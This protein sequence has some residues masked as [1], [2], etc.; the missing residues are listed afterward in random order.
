M[1]ALRSKRQDR[2]LLIVLWS[3]TVIVLVL[4]GFAVSPIL[5]VWG[6]VGLLAAIY[7]TRIHVRDTR[8]PGLGA[9]EDEAT[10]G[11][12]PA[13]AAPG[14]RPFRP[15]DQ[16]AHRPGLHAGPAP[17]GTTSRGGAGQ[18]DARPGPSNAMKEPS[19]VEESR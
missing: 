13:A 6:T 2:T 12:S 14:G 1:V 16:P 11:E 4:G 5:L 7:L 15:Q 19:D 18:F 17:E 9:G 10:A 8:S 3:F